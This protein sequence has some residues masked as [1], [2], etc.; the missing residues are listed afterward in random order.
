MKVP[1]VITGSAVFGPDSDSRGTEGETAPPLSQRDAGGD[2]HSVLS[3]QSGI[4]QVRSPVVQD[5]VGKEAC[6]KVPPAGRGGGESNVLAGGVRGGPGGRR[7]VLLRGERPAE[8]PGVW[9]R[10]RAGRFG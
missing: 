10:D 5:G 7:V 9:R 1:R 2:G 3:L 4:P 8:R 6:S